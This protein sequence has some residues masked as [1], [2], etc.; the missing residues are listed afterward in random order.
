MD[1]IIKYMVHAVVIISLTI[2][3]AHISIYLGMGKYALDTNEK[4]NDSIWSKLFDM[5]ELDVYQNNQNIVVKCNF[6]EKY[7]IKEHS[8][9]DYLTFTVLSVEG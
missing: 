2:C 3:I 1:K 6:K 8:A 5:T 4:F 9:K 7:T